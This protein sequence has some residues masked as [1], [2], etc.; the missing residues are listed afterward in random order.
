MARKPKKPILEQ[1]TTER[2]LASATEIF[3]E[4]GFD[5][6]TVKAIAD[7]AGVNI[8]LISYHFKGKEGIFQKC[9]EKFGQSRLQESVQILTPA[10]S[11]EDLRAKIKLWTQQFLL[12]QIEDNRICMIL[13]RE[14]LMERPFMR[15]LF[16]S[17]FLK[18][19]ESMVKFLQVAKKAGI[20]KKEIDPLLTSGIIY[21]ALLHMGRTQNIQKKQFGISIENESYRS[22]VVNQFVNILLHGVT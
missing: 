13:H 6:A 14:D 9:V 17:T 15:E 12:C 2:L 16:E 22:D 10:E 8:S 5:G 11:M 19:F 18:A 4:K 3:S 1:D 21:G 7:H 20:I